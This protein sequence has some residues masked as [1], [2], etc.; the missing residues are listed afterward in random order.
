[1]AVETAQVAHPYDPLTPSEIET[2]RDILEDERDIG[3]GCRYVKIVLEE[4]S[5]EAVTQFETTDSSVDREAF[6]I[7]RDREQKTT[8][9]AVVS[10]TDSTVSSWEEK[11]DVQ[12]SITLTEFDECE[13]AVKNNE[14][15]RAAAAKRGVEEFDLAIIDPWS[16][17]H[18]LVPSDLDRDR[19]LAHGMTWIRTS[20]EDNGYARPLDGLHVWVDLDEMEVVKVLDRGTK[21]DNVIDDLEDA[22]YRE[23]DR[24][25][26]TDLK[27]YNVDQPEGPSWEIEGRKIE[28]QNWHIRI[29]WT[30]RE[31]LVLYNIGY[32]DD[33]EVRKIIHRASAA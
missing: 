29:G 22:K 25:L 33:G 18:H 4:P 11:P 21:V 15:W 13:K 27:P 24:E 23:Q 12:P 5:K 7:L 2:A 3:G 28:W 9:E 8:Y 31:G 26:R 32:E 10:L 16:V 14:E 30:Q 17:G 6:V 20:E 19:R 1:M